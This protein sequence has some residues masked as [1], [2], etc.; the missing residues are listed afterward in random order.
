MAK[1]KKQLIK[2][3]SETTDA[4]SWTKNYLGIFEDNLAHEQQEE[5]VQREKEKWKPKQNLR[6]W[7]ETWYNNNTSDATWNVLIDRISFTL[8]EQTVVIV[9]TVKNGSVYYGVNKDVH[10]KD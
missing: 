7:S 9:N 5:M 8:E 4:S 1:L 6:N 2:T 3:E 10:R